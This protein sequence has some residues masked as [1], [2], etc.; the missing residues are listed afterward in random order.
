MKKI[1]ANFRVSDFYKQSTMN[2]YVFIF[3]P[4]LI[5]S[6]TLNAQE[7]RDTIHGINQSTVATTKQKRNAIIDSLDLTKAQSKKLKAVN[8]EFRAQ[9]K[10]IKENN[11]LGTT[12][13]KERNKDLLKKHQEE[14]RKILTPDQFAKYQQLMK[15]YRGSKKEN[16]P[17]EDESEK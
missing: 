11:Q 1:L 2:K 10:D 17:F 7:K 12:E 4:F 14:I 9:L 13:R 8:K 3:V 15:Q 5:L 16:M 6:L